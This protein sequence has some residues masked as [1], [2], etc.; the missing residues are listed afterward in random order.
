MT[1]KQKAEGEE[2]EEEDVDSVL[3]DVEEKSLLM[4]EHFGSLNYSAHLQED[5]YQS[6][7]KLGEDSSAHCQPD[8]EVGNVL[9]SRT[10][11]WIVAPQWQ[12]EYDFVAVSWY[13][14]LNLMQKVGR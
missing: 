10:E 7:G 8:Y 13:L 3:D 9:L 1:G 2:L 12:N 11:K 14:T 6:G 5:V 4:S